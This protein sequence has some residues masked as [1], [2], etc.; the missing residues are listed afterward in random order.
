MSHLNNQALEKKKEKE[1][2]DEVF[3]LTAV[4]PV[5]V[6]QVVLVLHNLSGTKGQSPNSLTWP[7]TSCQCSMS[8]PKKIEPRFSIVT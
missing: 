5:V 4:L 8:T 2:T 1:K 3:K 7:Q 6:T